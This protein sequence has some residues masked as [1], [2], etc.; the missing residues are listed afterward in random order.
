MKS[1]DYQCLL[2]VISQQHIQA[3]QILS[4][5]ILKQ[6]IIRGQLAK[7]FTCIVIATLFPITSM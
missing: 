2:E 5:G 1:L 6:A 3:R 7:S 4:D